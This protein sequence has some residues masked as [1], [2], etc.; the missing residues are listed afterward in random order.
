MQEKEKKQNSA[1]TSILQSQCNRYQRKCVSGKY[2]INL[3]TAQRCWRQQGAS[4]KTQIK[5][6]HGKL[7]TCL[8]ATVEAKQEKALMMKQ[9]SSSSGDHTFYFIWLSKW[10][11]VGLTRSRSRTWRR[12]RSRIPG[13][14]RT[15]RRRSGRWSARRSD[16][17]CGPSCHTGPPTP[18]RRPS[19][20]RRPADLQA[21]V[22]TAVSRLQPRTYWQVAHT[23][24]KDGL[25]FLE[26]RKHK[27]RGIG[28]KPLVATRGQPLSLYQVSFK[29]IF[30]CFGGE[31]YLSLH[32][33][34]IIST[35][36]TI[37]PRGK[38]EK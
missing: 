38:A 19:W 5:T 14:S 20:P 33:L 29:C 1:L 15:G 27:I 9:H 36:N 2:K 21:H 31:M 22:H 35:G 23:A 28:T 3:C 16:T 25:V 26:S 30:W 7:L 4:S 24:W 11:K 32:G 18:G 34:I 12:G 8:I 17:S 37:F 6:W 10:P 13:R